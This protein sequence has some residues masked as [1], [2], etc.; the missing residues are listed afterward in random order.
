MY[1]S[2]NFKTCYFDEYT[3]EILPMELVQAAMMAAADYSEM[4]SNVGATLCK[5]ALGPLQQRR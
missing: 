4:K 3:G 5:D 1:D 2:S